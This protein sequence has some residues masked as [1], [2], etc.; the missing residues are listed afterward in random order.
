MKPLDINLS[1][2]G[3]HNQLL[4]YQRLRMELRVK[5]AKNVLYSMCSFSVT[6]FFIQDMT[7]YYIVLRCI[8]IARASKWGRLLKGFQE[9]QVL[10]IDWQ[11]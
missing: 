7:Y 6:Y 3:Q 9:I 11:P 2:P 1:E 10:C 5:V 8:C 4:K